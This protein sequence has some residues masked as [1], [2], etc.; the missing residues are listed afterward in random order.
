MTYDV[1]ENP[2]Q[3]ESDQSADQSRQRQQ[4]QIHKMTPV[5]ADERPRAR[6]QPEHVAGTQPAG[7]GE[8]QFA[9]SRWR[10]DCRFRIQSNRIDSLAGSGAGGR[11]YAVFESEF[12]FASYR[13]FIAGERVTPLEIR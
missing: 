6:N 3:R 7:V 12:R 9:G 13:V 11:Q 10:C 1:E 5:W 4:E 2:H 8:G